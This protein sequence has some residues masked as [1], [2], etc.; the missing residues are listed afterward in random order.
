MIIVDKTCYVIMGI[1]CIVLHSL[2]ESKGNVLKYCLCRHECDQTSQ[3]LRR[4]GIKA[5]PYHAGLTDKQRT[6][7]QER[8]INEDGCKV[9]SLYEK[10]KK[11]LIFAIQMG[12]LF[13]GFTKIS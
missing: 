6:E 7:I 1:I 12:L 13:L 8:W 2:N 9:R 3:E 10:N 5:E 4:S 11:R